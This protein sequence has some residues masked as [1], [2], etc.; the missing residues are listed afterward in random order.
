MI[1]RPALIGATPPYYG[2]MML[3]GIVISAIFWTRL[4]RRDD[5][6]LLVYFGGL[7]G[8]FLGA[9]AV[10]LL[11]DGWADF[12]HP[13][14]VQRWLTGKTVLGALLGGYGGV[15]GAKRLVGYSGATGDWFACIVPVGV[16]VGRVGCLL[17]GCCLGEVCEHSAWWTLTDSAGAPR[18]PSV[19]VEIAF[20]LMALAA[21]LVLRCGGLLPKQHFHLYLIGYGVFR[22]AHEFWRATPRLWGPF[23]G[24][25]GAA[26]AV[27]VLGVWGFLHRRSVELRVN[28]G[29]AVD[30]GIRTS[31]LTNR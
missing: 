9:K 31:I 10:Y 6:L 7:L 16:T 2:W 15:E 29:G 11:I 12:Q 28:R 24:Y 19:P 21:F 13:D 27:G 25:H 8:A 26:A 18:W 23:S 5:R 20:N 22:F 3:V 30:D 4:A 1:P 14:W 17:H